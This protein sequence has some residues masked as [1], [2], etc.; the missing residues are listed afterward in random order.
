MSFSKLDLRTGDVVEL[1]NGDHFLIMLGFGGGNSNIGKLLDEDKDPKGWIDC[2]GWRDDLTDPFDD[3]FSIVR[4]WRAPVCSFSMPIKIQDME[5]WRLLY[6]RT[7]TL[8][9]EEAER[10]LSDSLGVPVRIIQG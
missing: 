5:N 10:L 8:T 9:V 2:D 3:M 4:V 7:K 6:D 1:R